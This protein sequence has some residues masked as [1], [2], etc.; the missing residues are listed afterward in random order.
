MKEVFR[1]QV[2][3]VVFS[4]CTDRVLYMHHLVADAIRTVAEDRQDERLIFDEVKD[5]LS[6]NE[7]RI[8]VI[9][10]CTRLCATPRDLG[11]GGSPQPLTPEEVGKVLGLSEATVRKRYY[12]EPTQRAKGRRP[13]ATHSGRV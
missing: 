5:N 3:E 10:Q 9:D 1:I 6:E 8:Y 12:P 4:Y 7:A 2:R 11:V 13:K